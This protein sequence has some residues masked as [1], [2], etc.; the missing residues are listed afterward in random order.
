MHLILLRKFGDG[1]CEKSFVIDRH[2]RQRLFFWRG[3]QVQAFDNHFELRNME[4]IDDRILLL[5]ETNKVVVEAE[6]FEKR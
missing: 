3:C 6:G 2:Q 4:R 1:G 5:N